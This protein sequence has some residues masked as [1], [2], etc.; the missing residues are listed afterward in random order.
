[1]PFLHVSPPAQQ[2]PS[3]V[4]PAMPLG[5]QHL[6]VAEEQLPLQQSS[7]TSEHG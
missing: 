7:P 3:I 5:T 6:N 4:Q 2:S 1:V